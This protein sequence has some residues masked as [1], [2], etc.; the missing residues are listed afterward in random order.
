M[1]KICRCHGVSGSCALQTCWQS[2][3]AFTEITNDIKRMYDNSV[4]LKLDNSGN[5][6]V[7]NVREDQLV[8]LFGEL[9]NLQQ[10]ELKNNEHLF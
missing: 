6:N 7:K 10:F 4:I 3:N 8:Y 9:F 1:K 5:I 2:L